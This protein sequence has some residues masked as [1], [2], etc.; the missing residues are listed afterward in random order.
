[1]S[2]TQVRVVNNNLCEIENDTLITFDGNNTLMET[3]HCLLVMESA[4]T[5]FTIEFIRIPQ[6]CTQL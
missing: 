1:M 2:S 6:K 4:K 3:I 5:E